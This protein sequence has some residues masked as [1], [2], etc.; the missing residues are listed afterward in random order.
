MSVG[1]EHPKKF[2]VETIDVESGFTHDVGGENEILARVRQS[3]EILGK[4]GKSR[5]RRKMLGVVS[6]PK[7][8]IG[9]DFFE[10]AEVPFHGVFHF[11]GRSF[12]ISNAI[13][14]VFYEPADST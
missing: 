9:I 2:A 3:R 1:R 10:L 4:S 13:L 6:S 8:H 7:K 11:L 14:K 5:N 12:I